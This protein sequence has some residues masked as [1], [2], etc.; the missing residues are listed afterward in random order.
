[1]ERKKVAILLPWLKMGGT[2]KVA[3]RFMAELVQFC[4]VTLILSQ[5]VGELLDDIPEGVRVVI[6]EMIPFREMFKKDMKDFRIDYVLCDLIYYLK[7]KTGHDNIDNYRYIVER[8]PYIVEDKF[9]CAIS[10]HGQSPERLLNL[11]YRIH[12]KKKAVWIHG[13]MSFSEDKCRRLQKYYHFVDHFFFVSKPTQKS[14]SKV[15]SFDEAKA[16]VYYNPID[17][18][19]IIKKAQLSC[20]PQ[21]SA[22][23][24]NILTVGRISS[25]KGQDMIPAITRKLLDKGYVVRWYIIGDGNMRSKIEELIKKYDVSDSVIILGTQTNPYCFMKACTIYVQPSYTEGY[26]TT[27]CEAGMLG[28]AIIGTKPSGGIRDQITD[29]E[30]GLI[31]DATV[32]GIT[33]GIMEL[34]NNTNIRRNFEENILKKNFEGKG[35]IKKF[36]NYL[37]N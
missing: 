4:D 11:L 34:L 6:D 27:I 37:Y 21:F 18:E 10:Y 22:N 33:E 17:K 8:H 31:V 25:E 36:L 5:N 9:D 15:I 29:G 3:I 14:F 24:Q 7:V 20:I 28:K 30:D 12:S 2:N 19:E 32:D 23:Y 13:E 35:E 26:S 16:T 1:M